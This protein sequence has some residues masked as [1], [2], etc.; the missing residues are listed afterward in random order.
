[1]CSSSNKIFDPGVEQLAVSWSEILVWN[2]AIGTQTFVLFCRSLKL[3]KVSSFHILFKSP[4]IFTSCNC[5]PS[6]TKPGRTKKFK[7]R[8]SGS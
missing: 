3:V 7:L 6:L 1:M 2:S 5:Q 4:F 8:F